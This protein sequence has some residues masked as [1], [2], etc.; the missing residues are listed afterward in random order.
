MKPGRDR[1]PRRRHPWILSGA[2][3]RCEGGESEAGAWV[4]VLSHEGE[5]LG[6]GHYS[7]ASQ[8]R[9]RMFRFGKEPPDDDAL[10]E[11]V[12]AAARRREDDPWLAETDALRLVNAEGDGLPG[13]VIDRY[14]SVAV[15]R[16]TSVGMLVRREPV[17]RVLAT[18]PG[19]AAVLDRPDPAAARREKF[20]ASSQVLV[21]HAP[22]APV[23][24]REDERRYEVDLMAGQKTGFYLDQREARRC[25]ARLASGRRVL[26]LFAYTGGFA[27]AAAAAGAASVTLVESS[28]P[29]L[30]LAE[31]NLAFAEPRCTVRVVQGDAFRFARSDGREYDLLVIDPPPLAR[32]AGEVARASRA[33]KDVLM[34]ALRLAA[35]GAWMLA[36]S[37]SHHVGPELFRKI[38]FGASLDAGRPLQVVG[39]LGAPSDH[40]VSL[41]HPEGRYLSGLLLRL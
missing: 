36:F 40:P 38:V 35:P 5:V 10:L 28:A 1:A 12:A 24:I 33:Y 15:L 17:G 22:D 6:F 20:V 3:D 2:V 39:E 32:R 16:A 9:V 19:I 41:D 30:A 23:S 7:P 4:R 8:I 34:H 13:L 31:R 18:L 26:D 14:D 25:V 21:G 37:C 27:V 29:A 11:R